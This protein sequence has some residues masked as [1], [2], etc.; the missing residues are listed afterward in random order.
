MMQTQRMAS[1]K[2][3][4]EAASA[5]MGLDRLRDDAQRALQG[6][7]VGRAGEAHQCEVRNAWQEAARI[8]REIGV[9]QRATQILTSLA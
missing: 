6:G 4:R 2:L 9:E 3:E 1:D 8:W 5:S 7:V